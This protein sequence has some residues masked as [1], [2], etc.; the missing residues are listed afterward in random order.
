VTIPGPPAN[1]KPKIVGSCYLIGQ[2]INFSFRRQAGTRPYECKSF[3]IP[4]NPG[5]LPRISTLSRTAKLLQDSTGTR[6]QA[7]GKIIFSFFLS[8]SLQRDLWARG[9]PMIV[10]QS[11]RVLPRKREGKRNQINNSQN[12]SNLNLRYHTKLKLLLTGNYL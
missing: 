3:P 4:N 2:L 12:K 1:Q 8:K 5:L 11:T 9:K 10:P 7:I 6:V